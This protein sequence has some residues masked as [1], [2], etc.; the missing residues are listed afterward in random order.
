MHHAPLPN[1]L[2]SHRKRLG[3]SQG[4][5]AVLL[6]CRCGT[7]VSRYERFRRQPNLATVFAFEVIAGVPAKTLFAGVYVSIEREVVRRTE[8]LLK[9]L[10]A[11][12][13]DIRTRRR[14]RSLNAVLTA[15]SRDE[16]Q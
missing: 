15:I 2:R 13:E 16:R 14:I 8:A 6:G 12:P 7:K 1:Y 11:R 5:L 9:E 10:S 4:D 3:L